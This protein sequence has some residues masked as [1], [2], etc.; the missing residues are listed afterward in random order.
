MEE[1]S[2]KVIKDLEDKKE[3][4]IKEITNINNQKYKNIKS[5]YNDI[6]ASNLSLI[7]SLK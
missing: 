5:Y 1:Y 2:K 6:T 7:K 3:Q 4:K